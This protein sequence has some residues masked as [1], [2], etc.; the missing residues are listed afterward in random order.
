MVVEYH[1]KVRR[2]EAQV[3]QLE[4]ERQIQ[5]VQNE[6]QQVQ[7]NTSE[8]LADKEKEKKQ[9][10]HK[11]CRMGP[12]LPANQPLRMNQLPRQI[13]IDSLSVR[14]RE[15]NRQTNLLAEDSE[16][17]QSYI[18]FQPQDHTPNG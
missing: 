13:D 18:G 11:T 9:S 17:D 3:Q 2:L 15:A 10:I 1:S 12:K 4:R 8:D 6:S 14:S 16:K 5:P 7:D